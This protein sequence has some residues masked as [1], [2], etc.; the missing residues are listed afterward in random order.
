MA[1]GGR[2]RLRGGVDVHGPE[3]TEEGD[4]GIETDRDAEVPAPSGA[5]SVGDRVRLVRDARS[6]DFRPLRLG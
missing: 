6:C 3:W 5:F 4:E 2:K 1:E